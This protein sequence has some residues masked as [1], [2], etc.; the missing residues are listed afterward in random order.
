MRGLAGRALAV[1][2]DGASFVYTGPEAFYLRRMDGFE[3]RAIAGSPGEVDLLNSNPTF[4]PDGR[5]L[6]YFH[7]GFLRR[8]AVG[9]GASVTLAPAER[10]SPDGISWEADGTILYAQLGNGIWR[11]PEIGG[12]STRVVTEEAGETMAPQ[13]LPGGEWILYTLFLPANG[14]AEIRVASVATGEQRT[15]RTNAAS[16]R[17]VET[18]HLLYVTEGVL[19]AA[20][21]N[22]APSRVLGRTGARGRRCA[23]VD[24]RSRSIR[25]CRWRYSRLLAGAD[26]GGR[27]RGSH[28]ADR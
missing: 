17:Y 2:P 14:V 22:T 10:I 8:I 20:P 13:L 19:Y 23:S 25:R 3:E 7:A 12:S 26:P 16:A 1:S 4:S 9:G 5:Y 18:G 15:L 28:R 27:D 24:I 21:F 6:A 11:V